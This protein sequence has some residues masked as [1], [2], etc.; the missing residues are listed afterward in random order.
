MNK[1]AAPPDGGFAMKVRVY[2][3]DTDAGG[4]V[5]HA[6]YLAMA[7]KCR[8]EMLRT[9][10]FPLI[11][12]D[13]ENFIVKRAEIDWTAPARLDDL[14]TCATQVETVGAAKI[15]LSHHFTMQGRSLCRIKIK[16]VYVSSAIKPL[17][18]PE[19]LRTKFSELK[20]DVGGR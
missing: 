2:Y 17:K 9:F 19:M 12:P 15:D 16:L 18:M 3:S 20:G 6:N 5:Y 7:E 4:I 1:N 8:S 13:G 11:G 10:E 14:L